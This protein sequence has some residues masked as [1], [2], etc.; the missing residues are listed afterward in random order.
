MVQ[1]KSKRVFTLL[2]IGLIALAC[3]AQN[4]LDGK[5]YLHEVLIPLNEEYSDFFKN[6][7][8]CIVLINEAEEAIEWLDIG[9]NEIEAEEL[10]EPYYGD[11]TDTIAWS[12]EVVVDMDHPECE[13]LLYGLYSDSVLVLHPRAG[14]Y[15][16]Y[17]IKELTDERLVLATD[18]TVYGYMMFVY[19][20]TKQPIQYNK[21]NVI[22]TDDDRYPNP[23]VNRLSQTEIDSNNTPAAVAYNF[24]NAILVS[25]LDRLL[26][27]MDDKT[28]NAFETYRQMN[29]LPNYDILFSENGSKLN[30][31]GWKPYLSNNCEVAVLYVQSEW[32]DEFGR[33]V[34]KVYVGCVLS[35]EIGRSGFQDVTEYGDT[36]VKVLVVNE[37]GGWK[38]IGFK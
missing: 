16:S 10:V 20:R 29:N 8:E 4:I 6:G 31:I 5:W 25:D 30:I 27:Y 26:S 34:K 1:V 13:E 21:H 22:Q 33:E 36:N 11:D 38:V 3:N 19:G 17:L 23:I 2:F 37:D 9:G 28:A 14:I 24:V 18:R 32:F 7:K 15:E 12:G 35:D